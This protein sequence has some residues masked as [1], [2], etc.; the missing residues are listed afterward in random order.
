MDFILSNYKVQKVI[1]ECAIVILKNQSKIF[2]AIEYKQFCST[3]IQLLQLQCF[4]RLGL[5]QLIDIS[6]INN[7]LYSDLTAKDIWLNE[8]TNYT[9]RAHSVPIKAKTFY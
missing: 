8:L 1:F 4:G 2:V 7:H 9:E 3:Y 6:N 5:L